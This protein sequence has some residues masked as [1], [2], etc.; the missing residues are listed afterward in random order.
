M[1]TASSRKKRVQSVLFEVDSTTASP[2]L[3]GDNDPT[4]V[5]F[6]RLYA[7]IVRLSVG[8][9]GTRARTMPRN[10]SR[11][12]A[13]RVHIRLTRLRTDHHLTLEALHR[14]A[15]LFEVLKLRVALPSVRGVP[16][17]DSRHDEHAH[18]IHDPAHHDRT[19]Q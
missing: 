4:E 11:R 14:C 3:M 8:I 6:T 18:Q 16:H 15:R 7:S 2:V 10:N 17:G 1:N 12:P 9:I 5:L 13:T 19:L